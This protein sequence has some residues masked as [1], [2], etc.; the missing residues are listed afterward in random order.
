MEKGVEYIREKMLLDK[1]RTC[2]CLNAQI[3][4][5]EIEYSDTVFECHFFF[6]IDILLWHMISIQRTDVHVMYDYCKLTD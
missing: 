3:P 5:H 4:T 2:V 1:R 6:L